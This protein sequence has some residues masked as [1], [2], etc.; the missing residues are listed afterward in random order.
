MALDVLDSSRC[1]LLRRAAMQ[2][3]TGEHDP[4]LPMQQGIPREVQVFAYRVRA[5]HQEIHPKTQRLD[6][7]LDKTSC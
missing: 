7:L 4:Q 5:K 3:T 1:S 2:E 6:L